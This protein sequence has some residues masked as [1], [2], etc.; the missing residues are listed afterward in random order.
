MPDALALWHAL[1]SGTGR[2]LL[3]LQRFWQRYIVS[4]KSC[5]SGRKLRISNCSS[6][7][8]KKEK[9]S[10][11]IFNGF[12]DFVVKHPVF[13][14]VFSVLF[15]NFPD[16]SARA[17]CCEHSGRNIFCYH[18]PSAD[19]S[20]RSDCDTW[21]NDTVSANPYAVSN[22]NR[23]PV[24]YADFLLCGCPAV[25]RQTNGPNSTLSPMV[26]FPTSSMVQYAFA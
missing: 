22:C 25:Y 24:S 21:Q 11:C 16:D 2:H 14:I 12:P 18:A 13:I 17:A 3:G 5:A 7:S 6:E 26:I 4:P 1:S 9:V 15:C 8:Q 23:Y 20:I 19:D 10:F